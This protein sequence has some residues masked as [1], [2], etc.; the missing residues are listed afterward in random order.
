[1]LSSVVLALGAFMEPR[2]AVMS[3]GAMRAPAM[4]PT[5]AIVD[6]APAQ[7]RK[8]VPKDL[9]TCTLPCSSNPPSAHAALRV[10]AGIAEAHA[11][12]C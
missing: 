12:F 1:M 11:R 10:R 3:H 2:S 7:L 4:S 9:R 8:V 6:A 5:M